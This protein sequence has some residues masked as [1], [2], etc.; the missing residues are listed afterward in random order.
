LDNKTLIAN[1]IVKRGQELLSRPIQPVTFTGNVL[2]D[3]L[4]ND[5]DNFPHALVLSGIMDRQIKAERA[6]LIPFQI[7]NEIGGFEFSRLLQLSS[8]D[9]K[10][11]FIKKKLHRFNEVMAT[12]FFNGLQL[13]Q[14]KYD[15]DAS[16]I[17]KDNPK[18]ATLVRRFLEFEGVG[19]KIST[20]LANIL[21]RDFKVP[22]QDKICIDISPDI[23][24]T[25]VF[26][27]IGFITADA[28]IDQLLYCAREL[29]PEYPGIFDFSIWEIGR[30]WCRQINPYCG[31]CYLNDL[32]PKININGA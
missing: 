3:Q 13:I 15:N 27:R 20:M 23:Q 8:T 30:Q 17:W 26:K 4:L 16:K 2:A 5:L 11:I 19:V 1:R 32:C 29:N 10:E 12:N 31:K 21:A 9:L 6:W 14:K 28:T 22:M 7:S 24:V 25:K 18:S